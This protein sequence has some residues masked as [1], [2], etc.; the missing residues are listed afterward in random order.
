MSVTTVPVLYLRDSKDLIRDGFLKLEEARQRDP[1]PSLKDRMAGLERLEKTLLA[2][3][4]EIKQAL[5]ADFRKPAFETDGSEFLTCLI[6]IRKA[7]RNLK[8]WM[9]NRSVNTPLEMTGTRSFLRYE[10]K[11]VILILSPWNYPLNLSI[12]PLVAAWA[13]GNKIILKP[14]EFTDHTSKLLREII[15][16]SFKS[17]EV[18][19]VEGDADIAEFLI[20]LP[21]HHIFFTGSQ[22]KARKIL[23][24]T[25]ERLIPVTLELGGK[26]PVIIDSGCE[27][28]KYV[29]DIAF[30][31]CLNAGQTCIAPDFILLP[32][33]M[34]DVFQKA[35]NQSL[36]DFYGNH[37]I[38]NPSYCGII[39]KKHFTKLIDL[40]RQ[41]A[42]EGA[43]PDSDLE[44]NEDLLKI[45]PILL[46]NSD[47]NHT[48]MEDEI[49]G[50][51]LPIITYKDCKEFIAP[52]NKMKVPLTLYLF[53]NNE[54]WLSELTNKV[55]SGGV[56]YNNCLI[57]YCNFNLPFGG[58][59][60]SGSGFNHGKYG[61]EAFSHLRAISKQGKWLNILRLFHPPYTNFKSSLMNLFI[62]L[63]G[64]I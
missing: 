9:Q 20:Q 19:L 57:N 43:I 37:I 47:W 21:F 10:P 50:P 49:F 56:S 39:H 13:A 53:S 35:W 17:D 16:E 62:K 45:K 32:E 28:E 14:S 4:N 64:K 22:D 2:K 3:R 63:I 25:A 51:L 18:L 54:K 52:L 27:I 61:F 34:K 5:E 38:A 7:R 59:R 42:E 55:K 1:Y 30:A 31:K 46:W 36:I 40:V 15:H 11:G 58:L 6:E 23:K 48:T 33:H 24:M 8:F 41:S 29:K 26:T 44:F 12:I 60:E